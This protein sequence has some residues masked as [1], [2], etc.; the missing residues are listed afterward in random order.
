M[1]TRA[2]KLEASDKNAVSKFADAASVA[3]WAKDA[4]S[5][6]AEKVC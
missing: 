1:L 6:L 4:V 2:F 3:S 5:A